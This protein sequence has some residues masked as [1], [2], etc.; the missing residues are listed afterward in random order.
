MVAFE[1]LVEASNRLDETCFEFG[2]FDEYLDERRD[3]LTQLPLVEERD[4]PTDDAAAL[5]LADPLVD[6]GRGETDRLGQLRLR[7]LGVVLKE[8]QDLSVDEVE[9]GPVL[10]FCKAE[11]A[12]ALRLF[13]NTVTT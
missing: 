1:D 9:S 10:M 2:M 13:G 11:R 4:V 12:H 6:R 7:D 5:E 8:R 3:V